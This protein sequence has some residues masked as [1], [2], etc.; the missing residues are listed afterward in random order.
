[1]STSD[2]CGLEISDVNSVPAFFERPEHARDRILQIESM[3]RLSQVILND[4]DSILQ[5][6]T[7]SLIELCQ[8]DS[9][10][11]SIQHR[12]NG[13]VTHYQWVATSGQYK[14]YQNFKLPPLPSLCGICLD[15]GVPQLVRVPMPFPVSENDI[16]PAVSDGL[17][18]PWDLGETRGTIWV[19]AHGRDN[20][21]NQ[22]DLKIMQAF[23]NFAAMGIKQQR[24]RK[25]KMKQWAAMASTLLSNRLT[26]QVNDQLETIANLVHVAAGSKTQT[27]SSLARQLS[28]PL[29]D[30]SELLNLSL[31][32]QRKAVRPN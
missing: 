17:L 18:L 7:D 12:L 25:E 16:S 6:L 2:C 20:A 32:T 23:S 22:E 24:E 9:A 1:M 26:D 5:Q 4:A 30:L 13:E 27:A 14:P 8:A 21:F 11:I 15:R 29:E 31:T 10:G 28:I 19:L 3:E